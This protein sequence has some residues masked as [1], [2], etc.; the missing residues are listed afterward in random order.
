MV[1][2][3]PSGT[4]ALELCKF[5]RVPLG[6][7]PACRVDRP[8]GGVLTSDRSIRIYRKLGQVG[9]ASKQRAVDSGSEVLILEGASG[10][11]DRLA[12]RQRADNR[13][14]IRSRQAIEDVTCGPR[15]AGIAAIL[16]KPLISKG[17]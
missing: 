11:R 5:D 2:A 9:K 12:A 1:T 13:S 6:P 10:D 3:R 15:A 7:P 14:P 16:G 17:L 8:G 4:R